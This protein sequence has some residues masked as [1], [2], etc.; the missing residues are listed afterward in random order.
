MS[1]SENDGT[2]P[3]QRHYSASRPKTRFGSLAGIL[4]GTALSAIASF[5]DVTYQQMLQI[6]S[7]A[8]MK[9]VQVG[10]VSTVIETNPDQNYRDICAIARLTNASF[11]VDSKSEATDDKE[12]VFKLVTFVANTFFA[13]AG[14]E[15]CDLNW[16]APS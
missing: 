12:S 5:E 4:L 13:G 1:Y 14:Y 16:K 6:V 2:N 9:G 11:D 15:E 8:T 3:Y 10:T 7:Y